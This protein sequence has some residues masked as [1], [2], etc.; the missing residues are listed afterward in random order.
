M[1]E[2]RPTKRARQACEPC[3][4]KKSR[5]PG[6]KPTCSFCARLKQACKYSEDEWNSTHENN[7]AGDRQA[8]TAL[9]HKFEALEAKV[10]L[11]LNRLLS[12]STAELP[13]FVPTQEPINFQS[14][15]SI[16][17]FDNRTNSSLQNQCITSLPPH[18]VASLVEIYIG[19]CDCQPLSIFDIE[20]LRLNI[21]LLDP[22]VLYSIL[23]VA[24]RLSKSTQTQ[25][26]GDAIKLSLEFAERSRQLVMD[27]INEGSVE[28]S[29]FQALCLHAFYDYTVGNAERAWLSIGI[30]IRLLTS[31]QAPPE[32][33]TSD[34]A[35]RMNEEYRRCIWGF[36]V[37]ECIC[38]DASTNQLSLPDH[39][40]TYPPSLSLTSEQGTQKILPGSGK[41]AASEKAPDQ[42]IIGY[43]FQLIEIWKNTLQYVIR[44]LDSTEV[45]WSP[46][47][48]Y[49]DMSALV[50]EWE[51]LLCKN[52]RA[53]HAMFSQ[54]VPRDLSTYSRYWGPWLNVQF[55]YHTTLCLLNN[56]FFLW[57]KVRA[58]GGVAST[59]FLETASDLALL[60][61]KHVVRFIETLR[62]R[63]HEP[64]DPFLAYC[65]AVAGVTQ[66]WYSR[67]ED[68]GPQDPAQARFVTCF[69]FVS[70]LATTWPVLRLLVTNLLH[71]NKQSLTWERSFDTPIPSLSIPSEDTA[72]ILE[73]LS[74]P[75]RDRKQEARKIQ[76][77]PALFSA[78]KPESPGV[79]QS[80]DKL[81][82]Q[83]TAVEQYATPLSMVPL[84][85]YGQREQVQI[86][87][88][89]LPLGSLDGADVDWGNWYD[90]GN[91]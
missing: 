33:D 19:R 71:L 26:P 69:N 49:S 39:K 91:L 27:K 31:F 66:L 17:K 67:V 63:A 9:E 80:S 74:Y 10:D 64:S 20:I 29:V 8:V 86:F 24:L 30:G 35:R 65:A 3:R 46:G 38:S 13:N 62:Q 90:V 43:F 7:H 82:G 37:L 78:A 61:A 48:G 57:S 68:R 28:M 16:S 70:Q 84:D 55:T 88:S 52:H 85:Q 25:I 58:N 87:G 21:D 14:T 75:P 50:M 77:S 81:P 32:S 59:S 72:I 4:R 36:Y 54:Q 5:C 34:M 40:P 89:P 23:A 76:F 22:A 41:Y 44:S 1:M 60:H 2:L 53:A 56:P 42:G 18:V 79:N 45:P 12:T 11:V 83:S 6:E 73:V 47:S 15:L 51:S